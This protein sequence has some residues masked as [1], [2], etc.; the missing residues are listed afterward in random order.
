MAKRQTETKV[1]VNALAK[2]HGAPS[3]ILDDQWITILRPRQSEERQA[4]PRQRPAESVVLRSPQRE[5]SR[6]VA[7]ARPA[8]P[9]SISEE[10]R[11]REK[12]PQPT[13]HLRLNLD[14]SLAITSKRGIMSNLRGVS[15]QAQSQMRQPGRSCYSDFKVTSW[16]EFVEELLSAS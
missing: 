5:V 16:H 3:S 1:T 11:S 13:G 8:E 12:R 9:V 10:S 7:H 15:H 6:R 2:A 14:P 4:H